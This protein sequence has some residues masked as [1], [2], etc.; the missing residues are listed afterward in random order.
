VTPYRGPASTR[1]PDVLVCSGL[2]PSGG[3]GLI[4]D[5]RVTSDLGVRPSGVVTALTVQNTTGVVGCQACDPDL[6]GH[7]LAFLLTDIEMRAVKI[8]MVG[9]TAVAKAIANALHLTSAP[10]VWDPIL[11]PSRGDVPLVDSLFGD[12]ITALRPHL[13]LVTPNARELAFMTNLAVTD[14]A[15]AEAAAHALIQ[16]LDCAVLLKGGHIDGDE[17]IDVL[18]QP[19]GARDELRATRIPGGEHVHG[20]GCALSSAIAAYLAHG[21]DLLEAC[22]LAKDFVRARI[23]DPAR[24]GRGAPAVV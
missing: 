20:T 11:Y 15:S 16:R 24:P 22:Q 9:S 5:V 21:R 1:A 13:A 23:T 18:L 2:D 3:A 7:Q 8:G 17:S 6:I 4:A 10:V 14:L 19:S 12:A